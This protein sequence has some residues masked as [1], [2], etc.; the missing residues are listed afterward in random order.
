MFN[1]HV[2]THVLQ[3]TSRISIFMLPFFLFIYFAFWGCFY[4]YSHPFLLLIWPEVSA[5]GSQSRL[6][7][8]PQNPLAPRLATS[9]LWQDNWNEKKS[10]DNVT[11]NAFKCS[12]SISYVSKYILILKYLLKYKEYSHCTVFTCKFAKSS[13]VVGPII[14]NFYCSTRKCI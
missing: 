2:F 3:I 12:H 4:L 11:T 7:P 13:K 10:I 1:N 8:L 5:N 14:C 6:G 9:Q